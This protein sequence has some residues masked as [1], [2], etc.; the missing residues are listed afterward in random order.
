MIC[1]LSAVRFHRCYRKY[2]CCRCYPGASWCKHSQARLPNWYRICLFPNS[3]WYRVILNHSGS[4]PVAMLRLS[5][6]LGGHNRY[7]RPWRWWERRSWRCAWKKCVKA[8]VPGS[9]LLESAVL[10]AWSMKLPEGAHL[11]N[12]WARL[13]L[14]FVGRGGWDVFKGLEVDRSDSPYFLSK[15]VFLPF[16]NQPQTLQDLETA[17]AEAKSKIAELQEK[18][19]GT[20]TPGGLTLRN[21]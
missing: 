16:R 10:P 11:Y 21:W 18:T 7:Q 14:F 5:L 13:S 3:M 12:F 6:P 19:M 17:L 9:L 2:G 4:T 8:A 15:H 1:K 20:I